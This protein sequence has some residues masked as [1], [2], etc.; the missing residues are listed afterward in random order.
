MNP[1]FIGGFEGKISGAF[2]GYDILNYRV[3]LGSLL[4]HTNPVGKSFFNISSNYSFMQFGGRSDG[5]STA[6]KTS[7]SSLESVSPRS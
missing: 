5:T 7:F 2:S 6:Q 1:H 4:E 3:P